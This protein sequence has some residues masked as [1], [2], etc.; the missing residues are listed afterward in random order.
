M[1]SAELKTINT[2]NGHAITASFFRPEGEAKATV[3]MVPAM[4][5]SQKY[6]APLAAW[7]AA[8][9][10]VV[11]TFDYSGTGLSRNSDLRKLDINIIDWAQ[12]DCH[13]M[14]KAISVEA[15]DKPLY[16]LGHS[17]G[18]QILGFVPNWGNI[19]KAVNIA[20]GS[21]YWLESSPSLKW[22]VW[23]LWY[24]VAPLSIRL[25]GYFPGKRLGMVGDLP[26]GVMAQWRRWCLDPNYAV[27]AEGAEAK[28]LFAAVRVPITSLSFADDEFMSARNTESLH[29]FY[30]NS[31]RLMKRIAPKDI[32][33]KRIGHFGFF[34][35]RFE[36][37]LWQAYLLPEL[38]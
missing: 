2:E 22:K 29:G 24:V 17:L 18:G 38:S 11:A 3:L 4:G 8:Q 7:L 1:I 31:Q 6:Y 34:K 19:S 33:V 21:G 36:Q 15:P 16:W 32:G 20:S 25:F 26:R 30:V 5:A 12:F 37:S 35:E 13:A 9:G 23:W 27:G 10:F 14:I 28:A